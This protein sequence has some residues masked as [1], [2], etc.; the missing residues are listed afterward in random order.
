[1]DFL[2][3]VPLV[4]ALGIGSVIGNY[5]GAGKA[6]REVRSAVLKALATTENARWANLA[7]DHRTFRTATRDLETAALIARIPR[8]AV[9][10]YVLLA[11]AAHR[12]SLEDFEEKDGEEEMG[13]GS[14]NS[15]LANVVQD[16][17]E[18]IT[19]LTWRPWWSRF[20]YRARLKKLRDE[21]AAIDDKSVERALAYAQWALGRSSG[22]LGELHDKRFPKAS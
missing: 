4:G 15:E 14:V 9:Q 22:A 19:Q 11:D 12:Y 10:Q 7:E 8:P 1:M 16:S 5:I 17:A 20:T 6:R 18:V 3:W 2:Q 13:A 21:A